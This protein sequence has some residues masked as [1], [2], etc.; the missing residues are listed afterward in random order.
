MPKLKPLE[1]LPGEPIHAVAYVRC[2]SDKQADKESSIPAQRVEIERLAAR[3]GATVVRW[4]QDDGISGKDILHRPGITEMLAY[5]EENRG[6]ISALYVYDY[7]RLA[8]MREDAFYIRKKAAKL[9]V[10]IV[11]VA[12]PIVDD[13]IGAILQESM[14]DAWAEIERLNLA[15]V[16]RRG[17]EQTLRD[18]YWPFPRPP[19]GYRIVD[20]ANSRGST[21]HRLVPDPETGPVVRR[22]FDLQAEGLGQKLIAAA[23]DREGAPCPSREDTPKQRVEGWRAKH[24][25]TILSDPRYLGWALWEGEVVN[26]AHHEALIDRATFDSA[27]GIAAT[28]RRNPSELGTLNTKNEG[29]FRPWLRCGSCGGSMA[30]NRGGT[31]SNRVWYYACGT[32]MQKKDACSG[33][34]VRVDELDAALFGV[35]EAE[36][37]TED[38]VVKLI[39]SALAM[40]NG[41]ANQALAE[42]RSTLVAVLDGIDAQMQKITRAIGAG[43]IDLEDA[44]EQT[45]PLRKRRADLREELAG[46]PEPQPIPTLDEIDTGAFRDAILRNWHANEQAVQRKA[47]DRLIV[48]VELKP[49]TA[50]IRYSWKAEPSGYTYQAPFGPP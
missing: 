41:S 20:A 48:E 7:K 18:G 14:Y 37:L 17:Q 47:L 49:G 39:E 5:M 10:S 29:V 6:R 30:V 28:R 42:R 12:Q 3:S 1:R 34:T 35:M 16:V 13:P 19:Y 40:M 22:I 2:S 11:S 21:R 33:L 23:L 27:Q 46:L 15:R 8:R 45:E 25:G 43:V 32:R 31:P 9:Q 36:I 24:V 4:F 50:L 38:N 26:E 44:R